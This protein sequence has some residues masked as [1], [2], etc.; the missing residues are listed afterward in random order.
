MTNTSYERALVMTV[1]AN[2]TGGRE[3][4]LFFIG[5]MGV[6]AV[7]AHPRFHRRVLEFSFEAVIDVTAE[8]YAGHRCAKKLS[9]R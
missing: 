4:E 8:T 7:R 1:E 9:L 6:M 2:F 3:K 5:L